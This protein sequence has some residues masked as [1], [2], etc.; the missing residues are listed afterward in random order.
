MMEEKLKIIDKIT[1]KHPGYGV[2]RGWSHYTGGMKDSGDWYVR[3][4][5][6]A[7][8]DDLQAFWDDI[9]AQEAASDAITKQEEERRAALTQE[10]RDRED[11]IILF[12]HGGFCTV[13]FKEDIEKWF[14]EREREM[15]F[16]L[17]SKD[18]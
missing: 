3:L 8:L 5:L 11:A 6:D 15:W 18:R 10:E 2:D 12:G 7:S 13:K 1:A 4:M 17:I 9:L 14:T 16:K